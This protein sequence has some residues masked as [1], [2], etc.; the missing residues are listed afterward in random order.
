MPSDD[1]LNCFSWSSEL[2]RSLS[3][4]LPTSCGT[5]FSNE[6]PCSALILICY[7]GVFKKYCSLNLSTDCLKLLFGS[8]ALPLECLIGLKS[9]WLML[10]EGLLLEQAWVVTVYDYSATFCI[11]PISDDIYF[12]GVAKLFFEFILSNLLLES[13]WL[14][15]CWLVIVGPYSMV[16]GRLH[17]TRSAELFGFNYSVFSPNVLLKYSWAWFSYCSPYFLY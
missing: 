17:P 6:L 4:N 15:A 1:F 7:S 11:F 12:S 14:D 9:D 5:G 13:Y 3:W 10:S 8:Q 16:A 2:P